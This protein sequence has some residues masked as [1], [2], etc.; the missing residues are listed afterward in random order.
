MPEEKV[1]IYHRPDWHPSLNELLGD[2]IGDAA[3]ITDVGTV[4]LLGPIHED[5]D[6]P[7]TKSSSNINGPTLL[8]T[9]QSSL[10]LF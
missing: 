3:Y 8:L 6:F 9:A 5:P 10:G 1:I 2:F 4:R 7:K